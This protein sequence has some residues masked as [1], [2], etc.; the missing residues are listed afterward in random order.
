MKLNCDEPLSNVAFNFNVHRYIQARQ[1][2]AVLEV[3][4]AALT[5]MGKGASEAGPHIRHKW[6]PLFSTGA[7]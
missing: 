6:C 7:S 2:G 4:T 3:V 5:A 1:R